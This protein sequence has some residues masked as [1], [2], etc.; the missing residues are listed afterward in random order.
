MWGQISAIFWAQF[1]IVRNR[2][3]RTKWAS[4]LFSIITL[5]WYGFFAG[6]GIALALRVPYLS[7][8]ELQKWV[9]AGLLGVF[10]FWQSVPLITLTTGAS[11]QLNKIQI[12]PVPD[13]G[14]FGIEV[15]LRLTSS[16]EMVLLLSG[17]F[18]GLLRN[19]SVPSFSAMCL[20]FFVAIN[21]FFALAIRETVLHS[22]ERNRF[23]ELFAILIISI[24][25][26]PQLLLRSQLGS[27]VGAQFFRL[28][29]LPFTPWQTVAGATLSFHV[30]DLA[31]CIVWAAI[32]YFAARELFRR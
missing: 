18:F 9:P 10:L 1:R 25:I 6:W 32:S 8:N 26:I 19:P 20:L 3:P 21:L 11:L 27:Q 5:L 23:R 30:P 22:F 16:P 4:V 14:L 29:R 15:L 13:R 7:A 24:G 28:A 17:A 12:Y 31:G 2:F